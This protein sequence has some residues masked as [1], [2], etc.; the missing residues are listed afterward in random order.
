MASLNFT[1][2]K[3]VTLGERVDQRVRERLK[4]E[5][6]RNDLS[7]CFQIGK[8]VAYTDKRWDLFH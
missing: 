8:Y 1:A 7:K 3:V 4:E 2:R 5:N 6:K